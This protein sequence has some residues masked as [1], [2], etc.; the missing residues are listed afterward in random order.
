[1]WRTAYRFVAAV[2]KHD[3]AEVFRR[4]AANYRERPERQQKASVGIERDNPAMREGKR[5]PQADR[6]DRAHRWQI[7]RRI[8]VTEVV[9]FVSGDPQRHNYER[10][11]R[12]EFLQ[13][14][15]TVQAVHISSPP[16]SSA[17]WLR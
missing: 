4:L 3:H 15:E 7:H 14:F 12:H 8:A 17:A 9:P 1:G 2:I 11:V 5:E 10:V 6:R 16:N 13:N